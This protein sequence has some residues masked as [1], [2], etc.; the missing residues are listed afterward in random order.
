MRAVG[1][2]IAVEETELE[3]VARAVGTQLGIALPGYPVAEQ[4]GWLAEI[5]SLSGNDFD[6]AFIERLRAANGTLLISVAQVRAA[7]RND[8]IRAFAISANDAVIRELGYLEI[9]GLVNFD[10]LPRPSPP[11]GVRVTGFD[12]DGGLPAAGLW[13]VLLTAAIAGLA[14]LGRL[15]QSR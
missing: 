13:V 2:L 15:V 10:S 6:R 11:A 12:R 14:A 5:Q 7:T 9:S 1:E 3:A 8:L 4:R